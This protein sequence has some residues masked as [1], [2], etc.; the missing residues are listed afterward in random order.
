M[1]ETKN[2]SHPHMRTILLVYA[3]FDLGFAT[4]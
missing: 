4:P 2:A 3:D 1:D